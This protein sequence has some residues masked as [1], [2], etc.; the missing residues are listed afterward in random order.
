MFINVFLGIYNFHNSFFMKPYHHKLKAISRNTLI[1]ELFI[2]PHGGIYLKRLGTFSIHLKN[3]SNQTEQKLRAKRKG[4][5]S[6]QC[7]NRQ[8]WKVWR[9]HSINNM[10]SVSVMVCFNWW[11][12]EHCMSFE[13]DMCYHSN[14]CLTMFGIKSTLDV[15]GI[16]QLV[17]C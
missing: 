7:R 3:R 12:A 5:Y 16:I 10:L 14:Q 2:A 9:E 6:L 1:I 15:W 8:E 17:I 13:S 11:R 4:N